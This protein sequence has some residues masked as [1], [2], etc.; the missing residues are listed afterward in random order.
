MSARS[1][2]EGEGDWPTR[3]KEVSGTGTAEG[4]RPPRR[5]LAIMHVIFEP[6]EVPRVMVASPLSPSVFPGSPS[7]TAGSSALL[8]REGRALTSLP[9]VA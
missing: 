1:I 3:P 8:A 4:M 5:V 7:L 9:P 6:I 2:L